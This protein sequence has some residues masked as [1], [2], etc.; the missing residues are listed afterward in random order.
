MKHV[1]IVVLG[2]VLIAL[3][4]LLSTVMPVIGRVAF[5]S[6]AAGT[7]SESNYALDLSV[8]YILCV[9]IIAI[10]VVAE[11]IASRRA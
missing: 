10:G 4:Q 1:W 3:G 5:Q 6:A 11:V 8:Y 7:F 2:V 9:G